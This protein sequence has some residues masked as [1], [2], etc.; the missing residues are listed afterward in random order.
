MSIFER[1]EKLCNLKLID[2]VTIH[3]DGLKPF[4]CE[5]DICNDKT[6]C[7]LEIQSLFQKKIHFVYNP[8]EEVRKSAI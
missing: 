5:K 7:A 4:L 1:P 3:V 6:L 2:Y 8:D